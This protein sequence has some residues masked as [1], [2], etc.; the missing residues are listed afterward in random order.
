MVEIDL[1]DEAFRAGKKGFERTRR[2]LKAWPARVDLFDELAGVAGRSA[3]VD[4]EGRRW[5][6]LFAFVDDDGELL[7]RSA[8]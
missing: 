2:L 1:R 8:E 3:Q 4:G 7:D 5:D 6:V